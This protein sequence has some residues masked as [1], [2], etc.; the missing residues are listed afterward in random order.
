MPSVSPHAFEYRP[1]IDGLRAIAVLSVFVFHLHHSWLPGGFVGVDVFFVISGFLISSIV[2]FDCSANRFSIARFYQRRISR[3]F[4]A[5]FAVALFT[6]IGAMALYSSQDTASAGAALTS[7]ALS[8]VNVKMMMQGD[9][10]AISPDAQP[11]LHYWSLSVEEQFYVFFPPLA[12]V[13]FR[14]WRKMLVPVLVTIFAIS[15]VSCVVITRARPVW[16][17]YLLPTRAWELLA[18]CILGLAVFERRVFL[19]K[20]LSNVLGFAGLALVLASLFLVREGPNFPG[21]QAIL[22]VLGS[23][24]LLW[25][26]SSGDGPVE[27]LLASRWFV[28]VGKRSY[29]LYL[30]HW[31]IF[32]F[33]DYSLYL[34]PTPVRLFMKIGLSIALTMLSY[35][36]IE[37]GARKYLNRPE[38]RRAAYSMAI[39]MAAVCVIVGIRVQQANYLNASL[40]TVA[41]GGLVYES[42]PSLRTVVLMG[43]SHGSMYG[44]L[45]KETCAELH[46]RLIV[47]SVAAEDPLPGVH[48]DEGQLWLASRRVIAQTKPDCVVLAC[49]WGR[50]LQ[51]NPDRARVAVEELRGLTGRLIIL[52]Q[53]P[54][55]PADA[56]RDSIRNGQRGPFFEDPDY[57]DERLRA[58][59]H[60]QQL[61]GGNVRLLDVC[62]TFESPDGSVRFIDD[63]GRVLYQDRNHLS[64]HGV[65]L[66]RSKLMDAIK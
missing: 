21:W 6:L 41:D 26:Q 23:V 64:D 40:A 62:S 49:S 31:P 59:E 3:I 58:N 43:D 48:G 39:A 53:P 25:P 9:Y 44:K 7:S 8:I 29:S 46:Y 15:L 35:A 11:F 4:P 16:G 30:W 5:F 28:F 1:A 33:V 18:G 45:L 38:K 34:S 10:F 32:S 42:A 20:N 55:L 61:P 66:L 36:F 51:A 27:K 24:L 56:T 47:I 12:Y 63:A 65:A 22:P 13:L 50:K 54:R 14:W 37:T 19:R 52:N 57:R 2:Y 17:F 60:L